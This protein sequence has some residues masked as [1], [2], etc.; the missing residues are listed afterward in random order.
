MQSVENT[1]LMIIFTEYLCSRT[2][3]LPEIMLAGNRGA[4]VRYRNHRSTEFL[5]TR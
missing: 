4:S 1:R 3:E 2:Y 5:D